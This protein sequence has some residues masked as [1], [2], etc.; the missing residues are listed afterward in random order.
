MP[1]VPLFAALAAAGALALC[2]AAA[3]AATSAQVRASVSSGA[4]WLDSQQNSA[5]TW[6]A[7]GGAFVP[8]ALA[9]AGR[10][11]ADVSQPGGVNARTVWPPP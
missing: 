5:G 9:A 7:F 4:D 1:R 6:N 10:N 11:A 8:S 2:P 3:P